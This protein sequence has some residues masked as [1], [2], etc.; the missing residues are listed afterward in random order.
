[1]CES[2]CGASRQSMRSD[3]SRLAGPLR[4]LSRPSCGFT[5]TGESPR[6]SITPPS[7]MNEEVFLSALHENP[8]DEVTW[9]ALADWLD[10]AGRPDRAALVRLL[11]RRRAAPLMKRTKARAA[12][13]SR[14]AELLTAGVRPAVPEVVNSAGIR[15]ALI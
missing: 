5:M 11:R 8:S 15:L 2:S 1:M 3:Q 12:A 7:P 6:S 14:V 13:E 9:L 4:P 10:E